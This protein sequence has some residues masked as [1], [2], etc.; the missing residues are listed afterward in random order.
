M[1][2]SIVKDG[3]S[4]IVGLLV[5]PVLLAVGCFALGWNSAA[6]GLLIAGVVLSAFMVYFFR[7]PE[8]VAPADPA[9]W[10]PARTGWSAP[11][12]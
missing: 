7:N 2:L 9:R 12:K 1:R 10:W 3:W 6:I 8:R 4:L 11:W 5:A